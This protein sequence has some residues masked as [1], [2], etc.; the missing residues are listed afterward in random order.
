MNEHVRS[1]AIEQC[2]N[3]KNDGAAGVRFPQKIERH[4]R[5]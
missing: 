3:G 5:A 2:D 1:A 4:I